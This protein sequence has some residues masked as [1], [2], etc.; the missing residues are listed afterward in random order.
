M[1]PL[2]YSGKLVFQTRRNLVIQ[3]SFFKNVK[4]HT[5]FFMSNLTEKADWLAI[6]HNYIAS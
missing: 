6:A 3:T 4:A 5:V 1:N 2:R